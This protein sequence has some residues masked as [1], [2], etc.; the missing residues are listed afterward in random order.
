MQD[1]RWARSATAAHFLKLGIRA[2]ALVA[3][4]IPT[5]PA[6]QVVNTPVSTPGER[7]LSSWW[8]DDTTAY[9]FFEVSHIPSA[10][11]CL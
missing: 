9:Q 2:M 5:F 6:I 7:M 3:T 10:Q 8:V 11:R 1:L 4:N